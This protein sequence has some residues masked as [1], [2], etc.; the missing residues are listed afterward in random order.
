M[1]VAGFSYNRKLKIK[2]VSRKAKINPLYYQQNILEPF[3][4]EEIPAFYGNDIDKVELHM[5][6][7]LVTSLS[8]LLLI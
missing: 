4:E 3:F 2:K 8:Q 1:I 6:K 5:E 7:P